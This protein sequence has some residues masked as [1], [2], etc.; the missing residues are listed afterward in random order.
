MTEVI[1][2]LFV[3]CE[4]DSRKGYV[5]AYDI[6]VNCSKKIPFYTSAS[7]TGLRVPLEDTGDDED[8]AVLDEVMPWLCPKIHAWLHEKKKVLIHC[9][10]AQSR[11]CTVI[12]AYLIW[13]Y[14]SG[15]FRTLDEVTDFVRSRH[16]YAFCSGLNYEHFLMNWFDNI[17]Q[18]GRH[19]QVITKVK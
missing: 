6:V 2:F 10:M 11:S 15:K 8:N 18:N 1:P 13:R 14:A 19:P 4:L 16:K 17:Q 12:T 3:G 5:D 7:Q 9:R